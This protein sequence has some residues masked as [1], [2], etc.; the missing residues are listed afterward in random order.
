MNTSLEWIFNDVYTKFKLQFYRR[1]FQRFEIREA[2]LSTVEMFSVEMIY[3]LGKPTVSEFAKFV[4][5]S[6]ANATYR[7]QGLIRKGYLR[8]E[9]SQEDRRESYLLVTERFHE[10]LRL[11]TGYVNTVVARIEKR[12]EPGDVETFRR[13]LQT[14][15]NELM[16]E[17]T[18]GATGTQVVGKSL[19]PQR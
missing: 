2:S 16:P 1:I 3:S 14:I 17:A 19:E 8:K 18:G 6:T 10:Y 4:N 5:I 11:S 9:R 15:S 7:V 13:I 12:F